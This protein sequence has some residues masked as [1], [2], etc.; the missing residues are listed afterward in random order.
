MTFKNILFALLL[1]LFVVSVDGQVEKISY[2]NVSEKFKI[3]YNQGKFDSIFMMFA[4]VIKN[5]L[6]LDKTKELL[7]G[8][9]DQ[10][11]NILQMDFIKYENQ[12]YAS[13]KTKFDRNLIALNIALDNDS[14]INGLFFKPFKE[15]NLP[16]IKRNQTKLILPF[17][18]TWFVFWGGDTKELNYHVVSEAQKNAFDFLIKDGSGKSFKTDGKTNEDYYCFGKEILSPCEGEIVLVVDGIKDNVP[19][20]MNPFNAGGNSIILKTVNNEFL[21]FGHFKHQSIKVKEGQK[22]VQGQLLGLCGN[23]GN[24]TEAHLHFHIQNVEDI[25]KATGVKCFF[26]NVI[27]DGTAKPDYS[28]IKNDKVSNPN[29]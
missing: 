12:V 5:A 25:N 7:N 19:G 14:K 10:Y 27:V 20:E 26:D 2:K 18:D 24:S 15:D 11:G 21:F 28:P 6:P 4:D 3:N 17:K 16:I 13:Y 23:S 9:K 22:V 1:T 8:L 29:K